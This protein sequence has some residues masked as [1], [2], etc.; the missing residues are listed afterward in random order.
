MR[1]SLLNGEGTRIKFHTAGREDETFTVK[2]S[3]SGM[4]KKIS[5]KLFY[6]GKE[7]HAIDHALYNFRGTCTAELKPGSL[8]LAPGSWVLKIALD[9]RIARIVPFSVA[10]PGNS[11]AN[12]PPEKPV[13]EGFES[14]RNGDHSIFTCSLKDSLTAA[15]PD[16]DLV[17]YRYRWTVNGKLA[18]NVLS[19]AGSDTFSVAATPGAIV[20]CSASA[21]DGL[22]ESEAATVP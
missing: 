3:N 22:L 12:R 21:W 17:R 1:W 16:L 14:V 15:D 5:W 11:M 10:A 2:L 20:T 19:L 13:I 6:D 8:K 4:L 18:R 7:V 9:G